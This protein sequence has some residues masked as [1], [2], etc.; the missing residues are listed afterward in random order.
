MAVK[1]AIP[2]MF[3]RRLVLLAALMVLPVVAVSAQLVRLTVIQSEALKA[4]AESRLVSRKWL[5]TTRGRIL[6]RKGRV[7]AQD[8]PSYDI[9]VEYPVITGAWAEEKAGRLARRMH[10]EAWPQLDAEQREKLTERYAEVY[11][12]HVSDMWSRFARTAELD[13]GQL[14]ERRAEIE[15]TVD[16]MFSSIVDRRREQIAAEMTKGRELTTEL[17]ERIERQARRP[18]REQREAHALAYRVPDAVAFAFRSFEGRETVLAGLTALGVPD[19]RATEPMM[20]G[21][22]IPD[23]GARVYPFEQ[24]SASIDLATLPEPLRGEGFRSIRVQGPAVHLLGWMRDRVF[25]E[26]SERRAER[27][28]TDEMFADRVVS[29]GTDRGRYRAGDLIGA[30][31]IES[32]YEDAL[33]GLRGL[34]VTSLESGERDET[35]ATPGRDLQLSID[36]E[37]QAR[38]RAA[39]DPSLGLAVVQDWHGEPTE[40]MPIGTELQG[41]AVVLDI[42]TGETLAM[43][44]TP[45]FTREQLRTD[46]E[47]VYE[48]PIATPHVNR[49]IAV[50]YQPGSIV[51]PLVYC[52][53]VKTG[54]SGLDERIECT[55]HFLP[56]RTDVMR[57][58][59]Y[60]DRFGLTTHSLMYYGAQGFGLTPEEAIMGSCNIYFYTLGDRLGKQGSLAMYNAY[61]VGEAFDLGIG[62][63]HTG[64]VGPG[65]DPAAMERSDPIFLGIGQ[66]PVDWTPLH[67]AESYAALAR[68]GYWLSPR[69]VRDGSPPGV[70][71]LELNQP[72]IDRALEGLRLSV[73]D[74]RGTGHHLTYPD[75][76]REEIFN[77]PGVSIWGKTGT[78][79]ASPKVADPD[80]DGPEE[81]RVVR[82]GNHSWYVV[83]VGPE[84]DGP[85]YSVAVVMEYAGSGGRVSGP[86]CNQIVHALAAEGYLPSAD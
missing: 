36:I 48:D 17:E 35:P 46:P 61:G 73:S 64:R 7:L 82:S 20:P 45:G 67:A 56:G 83:M 6:D 22:E 77:V 27:V 18:I 33:R 37:L 84:G 9:A 51:K 24:L 1:E 32:S 15:S 8:R 76:S 23:A 49:A 40:A 19:D 75:G 10:A 71:S 44:S 2:S 43:V 63:E 81:P 52:E 26:D 79:Q 4:D 62:I 38:I 66:G 72:S 34:V 31:G 5:P 25:A 80:G 47:S 54:V 58:W 60:R 14:A 12:G 41:A 16:R 42:A 55:G 68:G 53:G 30:S 28:R 69:V 21:L 85:L 11:R 3:H 74:P 50:P 39:M 13:A 86:I 78:A 65:G 70:R 59:T 29:K 57:C